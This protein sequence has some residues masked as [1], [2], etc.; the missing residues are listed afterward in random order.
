MIRKN[1]LHND[2]RMALSP[3]T[4]ISLKA[5]DRVADLDFAEQK[6]EE[7]EAEDKGV[8]EEPPV[9]TDLD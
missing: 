8:A 5:E 4:E 2:N 7:A 9:A 6:L 3:T 1:L